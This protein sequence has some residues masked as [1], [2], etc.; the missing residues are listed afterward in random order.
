M[1]AVM[2]RSSRL[3][4]FSLVAALIGVACEYDPSALNGPLGDCAGRNAGVGVGYDP[5]RD[6]AA[7]ST[8]AGTAA[9]DVIIAA[10]GPV[11]VNAGAGHDIVCANAVTSAPGV[12]V[13]G[14]PGLD[15]C[16]NVGRAAT[17]NCEFF[18]G[19]PN[20]AAVNTA[21]GRG[22]NLGNILESPREGD[23]GLEFDAEFFSTIAD[24]G[25]THVRI[26]ISWEGYASKTAPFQIPTGDDPTVVHPDYDNIF[27]RVDW[28]IEQAEANGL[29]AI[30]NMHHYD[31]IHADPAAQTPRFVAMWNQ[32]ATR[33]ATAGQHVL[34]ELLNEPHGRFD[35]NPALWNSLLASALNVVRATNPTR[36]VVVGPVGYNGIERLDDLVLPSDPY[37][38]TTVHF[39]DP[40][41][42]THQGAGWIQP[43]LP[44]GVEWSPDLLGFDSDVQ[45]YSWSTQVTP[46]TGA[47]L[48]DYSAQFTGFF[49]RFDSPVDPTSLSFAVSGAASLRVVCVKATG[50][51]TEIANVNTTAASATYSYN[52][53]ACPVDT[54]GIFFQNS[55][56]TWNRLAFTD[57]TL[58]STGGCDDLID[59]AAEA[60]DERIA[61]AAAW[62]TANGRPMHVGE[63]G[64]YGL[65]GASLADRVE[66]TT[67]VSEAVTNSAM[68]SSYW[69]FGAG[70]G[71]YNPTTGQWIA[72]LRDALLN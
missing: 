72:P 9:S 62:G 68:S 38:I 2:M 5:A 30:V 31:A 59:S 15:D 47:M 64:A 50:G 32:I 51:E 20:I 42:F 7:G 69:E 53:S 45:N 25:F 22:I 55:G 33:Y 19:I 43:P 29:I 14:G 56:T 18:D 57:I 27:E 36:P 58:C 35:T 54:V 8:Y 65:G 48:V 63:F 61:E 21:L 40:F 37:L 52:L 41:P 12:V 4:A 39:Y 11:R 17:T 6:P 3:L 23:W 49:P 1:V 67:A 34:F 28:V 26:P 10:N 44:G 70:F 13:D 16:R 71:A 24:Q 60:I 66:W 46:T